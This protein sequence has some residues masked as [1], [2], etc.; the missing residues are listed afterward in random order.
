MINLQLFWAKQKKKLFIYSVFFGILTGVF[1]LSIVF[2][3]THVDSITKSG[4][5]PL[6]IASFIVCVS[7]YLI[8]NYYSLDASS[9]LT[10]KIIFDLRIK[11]QEYIL[12]S[13]YK[14]IELIGSD[15]LY[16][17]N[18]DDIIKIEQYSAILPRILIN[19]FIIGMIIIY[20]MVI[21]FKETIA[22]IVIS[23][24]TF[25]LFLLIQKKLEKQY[26]KSRSMMNKVMS[27]INSL[28]GG[29]R[30]LRVCSDMR[31]SFLQLES[32]PVL[33]EYHK[34]QALISKFEQLEIS[35]FWASFYII[36]A[37]SVYVLEIQHIE[38]K[39]KFIVPLLM[40]FGPMNMM[41][42]SL[43][44][45]YSAKIALNKIH[46]LHLPKISRYKDSQV[47]FKS[48][49][50]SN[51]EYIYFNNDGEK[52]FRI[53][54]INLSIVPGRVVFIVGG[55][56]C[57]KS[58]L[59]K[60]LTG[61]YTPS[62]GDVVMNDNKFINS[63]N[64]EE[65]QRYLAVIYQN[66]H[67]FST[68]LITDIEAKQD[69]FLNYLKLFELDNKVIVNE[70]KFVNLDKLSYGQKKRLGLLMS[71]LQD[72]PI[73]IFDEWAADQ[74]PHFRKIFYLTIIPE[75]R[76]MGKAII[77]VTH[78]EEYFIQADEVIQLKDGVQLVFKGRDK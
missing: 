24:L 1:N 75:L 48:A 71:L 40:I 35:W 8:S 77:A 50:L 57:G 31:R 69:E 49:K 20:M 38:H 36:L 12:G 4:G 33:G 34:Q 68:M 58:T 16:A 23:C 17:I 74:D 54:P 73:Y 6:F 45:F 72:K 65:Y 22:F 61:L 56:G 41:I 11:I 39:M 60:I 42:N 29:I 47:S 53:G 67:I 63:E 59:I 78:D 27:N 26:E 37:V 5:V 51:V 64:L 44:I 28:I 66:P 9:K 32:I 3:V 43:N 62:N 52:S 46:A 7:A 30:E 25:L 70:G 15:D 76:R 13:D 10:N 2:T 18:N 21:D 14:N 19:I 55:N